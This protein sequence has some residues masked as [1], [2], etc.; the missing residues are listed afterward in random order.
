MPVGQ[1]PYHVSFY[2]MQ[3][4]LLNVARRAGDLRVYKDG[5][6]TFG[7]RTGFFMDGPTPRTHRRS[8]PAVDG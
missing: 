8:R 3:Q 7:V 5:P 6:L 4:R 1:S 2:K